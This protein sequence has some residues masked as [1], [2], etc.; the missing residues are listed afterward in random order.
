[1]DNKDWTKILL[2]APKALL[3]APKTDI[4]HKRVS[5]KAWEAKN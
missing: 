1:M 4:D 5:T 2:H 3:H